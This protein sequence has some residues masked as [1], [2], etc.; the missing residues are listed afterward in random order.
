VALDTNGDGVADA[1]DINGDHLP[2]LDVYGNPLGN[3]SSGDAAVS[4]PD[5]GA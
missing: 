2:D 5:A 1:I 4:D 3:G